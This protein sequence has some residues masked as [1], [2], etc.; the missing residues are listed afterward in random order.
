MDVITVTKWVFL[1]ISIF[2]AIVS[3]PVCVDRRWSIHGG[4]LL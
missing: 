1:Y 2:P 4:I 3:G